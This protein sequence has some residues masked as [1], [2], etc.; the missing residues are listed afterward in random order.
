MY[1][2]K[3]PPKRY[4][5]PVRGKKQTARK[6]KKLIFLILIFCFIGGTYYGVKNAA[7]IS[8]AVKRPQWTEWKLDK[9]RITG[10]DRQTALDAGKYINFSRGQSVTYRDCV[11]LEK[12]LAQNMRQLDK[13]TVSRNFISKEL[14]VKI[15]KRVKTARVNTEYKMLYTDK[16]GMLFSDRE[17]AAD[18]AL[19]TVT[20]RGQIKSEILPQEFVE[21]IKELST[22]KQLKFDDVL[23]HLDN[24][25]FYLKTQEFYAQMGEVKNF[26]QKLNAL[27]DVVQTAHSKN[28]KPPYTINFKYFEANKIY[29]TP[30]V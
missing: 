28:F 15:K 29:L 13:I 10:A 24:K 21:L 16:S 3:Q 23:L 4:L 20:L 1:I 14:T 18:A 26:K 9:V 11:N 2:R 25:V 12:N 6:L 7:A 22:L 19:L 27:F 17:D 8:A 30:T 5:T